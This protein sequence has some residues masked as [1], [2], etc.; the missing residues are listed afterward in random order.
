MPNLMVVLVMSQHRHRIYVAV[1]KQYLSEKVK[2]KK[3]E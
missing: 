2:E 3:K 1:D